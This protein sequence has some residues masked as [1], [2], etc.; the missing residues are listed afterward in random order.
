MKS[1]VRIIRT[2]EGYMVELP[3][4]DYLCD[5]HGDN[6]W[7][8]RGEAENAVAINYVDLNNYIDYGNVKPRL[9]DAQLEAYPDSIVLTDHQMYTAL[10]AEVPDWVVHSKYEDWDYYE[11][12]Y[13]MGY[14]ADKFFLTSQER[15]IEQT[16]ARWARNA[17]L[18]KWQTP[19]GFFYACH[20]QED[21][22][23]RHVGFRYGVEVSQYASGFDGMGYTPREE[24]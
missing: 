20:K 7:E 12:R 10:Q 13:E 5:E 15:D 3:N 21:G 8:T 9:L 14:W 1:K 11:A 2:T 17:M 19:D 22:T 4:G 18:Y 24:K 23:Y 16:R 6:T